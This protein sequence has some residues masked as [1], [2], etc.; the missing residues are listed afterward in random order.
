[1]A[2]SIFNVHYPL[3]GIAFANVNLKINSVEDVS[4][5]LRVVRTESP[6]FFPTK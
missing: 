4:Q 6:F 1:M 5:P 2:N 3:C